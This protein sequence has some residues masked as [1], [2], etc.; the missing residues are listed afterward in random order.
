[1]A[2]SILGTIGDEI[3]EIGKDT[4]KAVVEQTQ[5]AGKDVFKAIIGMPD[6]KSVSPKEYENKTQEQIA[7]DQKNIAETRKRLKQQMMVQKGSGPS[8]FEQKKQEEIML[9][10]RQV[11]LAKQKQ[12]QQLP[13][14][15]QKPQRGNLGAVRK[16][17][18]SHIEVG[19]LPGQ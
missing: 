9:K 14:M 18:T 12:Q 11:E 3:K 4:A 5:E 2:N 10:Q 7:Q 19:K 6:A 17:Q 16:R 1:M 15:S 13:A 8:D